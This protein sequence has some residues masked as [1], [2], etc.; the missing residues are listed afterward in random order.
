MRERTLISLVIIILLTL[1]SGFMAAPVEKPQFMKDMAFWQSAANRD[2]KLKQ[3]LDLTGGLQVSLGSG[4]GAGDAV[5]NTMATARRVIEARINGL[6]TSETNVQLQGTDRILVEIPGVTDRKRALELIQQTGALEF[7]DGSRFA[8]QSGSLA[9]VPVTATGLA[10][11]TF[12]ANRSL[13]YPTTAA[14]GRAIT[15]QNPNLLSTAFTGEILDSNADIDASSGRFAVRFSIRPAS[16][17]SFREFTGKSIGRPLCIILDGVIL[18]CPTIQAALS[19]GGIITGDF[20]RDAASNL[21]VTLNYGALPVPLK[22][23]SVRDVGAT[24]GSESVQRSIIAG[25]IGLGVLALF[26]I[27][28]YRVPGAIAALSL[29]VFALFNLAAVVLVPITLSLPGIAGLLLSIATAV[30]ANILVLE[31]F[32]EELRSGRT[33]RA[34]VESAFNRAWPSVRDS[35]VSTLITCAILYLFGGAFGA[36]VVKGFAVNLVVG[37]F[38]SLFTTMFVT[39][40][41]LRLAYGNAGQEVRDNKALLGV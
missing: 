9:N 12:S 24:L 41:F 27:L 39:R 32:K 36:S 14:A 8:G 33:L 1:F 34:S 11:T 7:A 6:G 4:L 2:L 25:L 20:S 30:D 13:L 3:G 26:L 19:E 35:N 21:A 18:S 22:I 23:E 38:I 28:Y 37:I 40:T 5:T 29:F 10:G 15:E 16:R 17:E 31:R